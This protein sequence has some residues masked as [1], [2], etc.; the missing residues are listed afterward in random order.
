MP[1][2]LTRR[3]VFLSSAAAALLAA[4][5]AAALTESGAR[6]LVDQVVADIDRVISSGQSDAAILREFER[7]FVRYADVNIMAQ[8]A[9]GADGRSASSS[10]KRAFNDAFTSYIARKYGKQ[11]RDFIGGRVEVQSARAI[12]AGYEINTLAYLR[13]D[14]PFE[15]TFHVSDRSGSRKFFNIYIEGVNLLLTERS[16]IGAML[17]RRGGDLNAMIADL[18]SAG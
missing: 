4:T 15:V 8:Y 11:F 2:N 17:D 12:K 5:P 7:L 14:G 6:Q 3:D 16:E 13:G 9:L 1:S 18:K 10:Q